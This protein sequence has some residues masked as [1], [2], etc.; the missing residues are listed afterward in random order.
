MVQFNKLMEVSM[1]IQIFGKSKCFDTKKALRY[2]AER[3]IQVQVVDIL[4]K[5]LSLGEFNAVVKALGGVQNMVDRRAKAYVSIA[6]LA[7]EDI[8]QKVFEHQDLLITPIVRN[9]TFATA[10]YKPEV[11]KSWETS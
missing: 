11:W 9:G 3:S 2:F 5:G 8:A 6:Y 7:D 4:E 1:K 10:G